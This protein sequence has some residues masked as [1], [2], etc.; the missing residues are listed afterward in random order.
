PGLARRRRKPER[1]RLI[2][3]LRGLRI[4]DFGKARRARPRQPAGQSRE[5]EAAARTGDADDRNRRRRLAGRER[6]DGLAMVRHVRN[7]GYDSVS[8]STLCACRER[9]GSVNGL[10]SI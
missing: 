5:R 1:K 8:Y 10:P 6:K 4:T 7:R 3:D 9:I 2:D